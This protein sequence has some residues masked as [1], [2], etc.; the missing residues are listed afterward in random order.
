MIGKNTS[1]SFPNSTEK[2][3]LIRAWIVNE[4]WLEGGHR[5]LSSAVRDALL[6]VFV[7]DEES[8]AAVMMPSLDMQLLLQIIRRNAGD[9]PAIKALIESELG[10]VKMPSQKF[11]ST[12]D[13][14]GEVTD[15]VY[16]TP[17]GQ[18]RLSFLEK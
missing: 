12:E 6:L 17:E 7:L 1:I 9:K 15:E 13:V 16:E 8:P 10:P 5:T 4:G 14:F 2:D 18:K 3:K 11:S